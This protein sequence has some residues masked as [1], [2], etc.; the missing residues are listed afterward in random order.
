MSDN[1]LIKYDRWDKSSKMNDYIF[2]FICFVVFYIL[3]RYSYLIGDDWVYS[4]MQVGDSYYPMHSLKDAIIFQIEDYMRWSGRFVVHTLVSYFCGIMGMEIFKIFN[5]VVFTALVVGLVKLI[6]KEFDF[7]PAD[8]V[9]VFFLLFFLMPYPGEIFLGSIAMTVNYLWTSCAIVWFVVL[10]EKVKH[11]DFFYGRW[12]NVLLFFGALVVGSLQES[13]SIGMSG[14]FLVY[15]CF[16][17]KEFNGYV[18]SLVLGF[19]V[20]TAIVALAPGNF[21]RMNDYTD[22][23]L[24]TDYIIRG[25]YLFFDSKLLN[26]AVL[27]SMLLFIKDRAE[28][29]VFFH[30]NLFYYLTIFFN[31]AVVIFITYMG[32]RQLTCIELFSLILIVKILYGYCPGVYKYRKAIALTFAVLFLLLY[33]P[34]LHYRKIAW[35]E[36]T[37]LNNSEVVNG[38]MVNDSYIET[39]S[40]F[41]SNYLAR[42]YT[43]LVSFEDWSVRA[44]SRFKA[45]G[46]NRHLALLPASKDSVIQEFHKYGENGVCYNK[47]KHYFIIGLPIDT[48]LRKCEICSESLNDLIDL[49][50]K[51]LG[52]DKIYKKDVTNQLFSFEEAGWQYSI[53]YVPDY[54]IFDILVDW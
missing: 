13:F 6:R 17:R 53:C 7:R 14:A 47:K 50:N 43:Y 8:G 15:Y 36:A 1:K 19:W 45:E 48:P 20:G 54:K 9:L 35:K 51:I 34:V 52:V 5:S 25:A 28:F 44:F 31:T 30:K 41:S 33:F 24:I 4:F 3:N 16:H 49:K 38:I 2:I 23:S 21:T 29:M 18:L 42:R 32:E 46:K 10:Y 26:L 12:L 11:T 37:A 40:K 27:G 22:D 39:I